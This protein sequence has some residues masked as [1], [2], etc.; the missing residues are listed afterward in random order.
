MIFFRDFSQIQTNQGEKRISLSCLIFK[1]PFYEILIREATPSILST[2]IVV[3][4]MQQL[5]LQIFVIFVR[6]HVL[7]LFPF[8]L[9]VF[10]LS[11]QNH[12]IKSV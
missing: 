5:G 8:F 4:L 11:M 1:I 9:D 10:S 3:L 6:G 2:K 7:F 12:S